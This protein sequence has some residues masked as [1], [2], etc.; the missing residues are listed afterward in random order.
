MACSI[1]FASALAQQGVL[2]TT[3]HWWPQP[4]RTHRVNPK[5]ATA[6]ARQTS[7]HRARGGRLQNTG[8]Y[9]FSVFD[10][11]IN[12]AVECGT[13]RGVT[14]CTSLWSG[15]IE[16]RAKQGLPGILLAAGPTWPTRTHPHVT[17]WKNLR[18]PCAWSLQVNTSK[19]IYL[20][21]RNRFGGILY[22]IPRVQNV[23]PQ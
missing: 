4:H 5:R 6:S 11:R 21:M 12:T 9:E 15:M 13:S 2:I 16:E 19:M 1:F 8:T 10:F 20:F 17:S 3:P 22:P 7:A 23:F 18:R 14:R